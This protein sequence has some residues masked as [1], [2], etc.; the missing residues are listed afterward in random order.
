M[1]RAPLIGVQVFGVQVFG[2]QVF[3]CVFSSRSRKCEFAQDR[4][5]K[6]NVARMECAASETYI[7]VELSSPAPNPTHSQKEDRQA[8]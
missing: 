6:F 7:C 2:V 5:P 4:S 1:T 3:L 8:V